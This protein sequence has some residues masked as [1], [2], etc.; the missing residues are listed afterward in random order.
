[1]RRTGQRYIERLTN[2]FSAGVASERLRDAQ[3]L[4]DGRIAP[5]VQPHHDEREPEPSEQCVH[6]GA[7]NVTRIA[8]V[9]QDRRCRDFHQ[10]V[11]AVT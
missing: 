3:R 9:R 11:Q 8:P 4:K 5:V 1:M 7:G 6:D 10:M 2:F